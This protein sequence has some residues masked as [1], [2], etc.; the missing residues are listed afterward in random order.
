MNT[1]QYEKVHPLDPQNV[2]HSVEHDS[3]RIID[4]AEY[5]DHKKALKQLNSVQSHNKEHQ[6][7]S[8]TKHLKDI[9]KEARSKTPASVDSCYEDFRNNMNLVT[10]QKI[11]C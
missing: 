8:S 4:I 6:G 10:I 7:I 11:S 3:K 1:M 9:F 2:M 5:K